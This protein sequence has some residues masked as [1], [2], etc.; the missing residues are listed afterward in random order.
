MPTGN[1]DDR[2]Q[3]AKDFGL[4]KGKAN[5]GPAPEMEEITTFQRLK[6]AGRGLVTGGPKDAAKNWKQTKEWN[7]LKEYE[8]GHN[9]S[10]RQP[11]PRGG[12]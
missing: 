3:I 5:Y 9:T 10:G 12:S 1:N 8:R 6:A 2:P 7:Q 4:P 11:N